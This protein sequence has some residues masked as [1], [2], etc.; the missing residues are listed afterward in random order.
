[1]AYVLW[2][3]V[4]THPQFPTCI[5]MHVVSTKTSHQKVHI[6]YKIMVLCFR[7]SLH[8]PSHT[9]NSLMR[10]CAYVLWSYVIGHTQILIHLS[11]IKMCIYIGLCIMILCQN[12]PSI[13]HLH[14]YACGLY[15]NFTFLKHYIKWYIYLTRLWSYVLGYLFN[16]HSQTIW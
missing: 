4:K 5:Y 1:M 6:S 10:L 7:I 2:S 12:S 15:Q 14:I 13:P 3:Y 9:P 11:Y 16:G 8:W